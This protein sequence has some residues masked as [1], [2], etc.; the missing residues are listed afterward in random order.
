MTIIELRNVDGDLI[1]KQPDDLVTLRENVY[2][3]DETRVL[4]SVL[5]SLEVLVHAYSFVASRPRFGNA[6]MRF[7]FAEVRSHLGIFALF[8]S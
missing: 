7:I 1:G 2:I 8:C 4:L 6:S 5:S 3:M